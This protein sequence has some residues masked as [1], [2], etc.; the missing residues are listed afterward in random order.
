M[1]QVDDQV[2][3]QG[4]SGANPA[5][6]FG[7]ILKHGFSVKLVLIGVLCLLAQIPLWMVEDLIAERQLGN[8]Q[9]ETVVQNAWGGPVDVAM[10]YLAIDARITETTLGQTVRVRDT[11]LFVA[12]RDL[13]VDLVTDPHTRSRGIFDI[14]VFTA[15]NRFEGVIQVPETEDL[16]QELG[17]D[18]VVL[19]LSTARLVVEIADRRALVQSPQLKAN[20]RDSILRWVNEGNWTPLARNAAFMASPVSVSAKM[21]VAFNLSYQ[22][23]G[24][25]GITVLPTAS[26]LQVNL[27]SAWPSPSFAGAFL[28]RDHEVTDLGTSA[29][30]RMGLNNLALP[31]VWDTTSTSAMRAT[32]GS[33]AFGVDLIEPVSLYR[34]VERA[35]KYGLL[36]ITTTFLIYVLFESLGRRPIHI[37]HYGLVGAALSIFY[38]LLLSLAEVVGFGVAYLISTAAVVLQTGLFTWAIMRSWRRCLVF[39]GVLAAVYGYLYLLLDLEEMS[40]LAGSIGLFALLSAAMFVL[41]KLNPSETESNAGNT[42][43]ARAQ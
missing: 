25:R 41:R 38:V 35:V 8:E 13:K 18:N 33:M 27:V 2:G 39:S 37:V 16:V 26:E 36:F 40:L 6:E 12:A 43:T 24:S 22:V 4:E 17:V 14:V 19:D 29:S 23:Q 9:A 21:E 10:P 11:V 3:H 31:V 20:E 5:R 28:P 30:W 1:S 32:V 34:M 42:A 7:R 15:D